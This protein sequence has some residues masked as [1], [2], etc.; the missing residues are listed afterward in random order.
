MR[1][2]FGPLAPL[3]AFDSDEEVVEQ[4]ND[5]EFGL[6]AYIYTNNLSRVWKVSEALEYGMV[7]VNTPV[8]ATPEAL[9][10]RGLNPPGWA[11]RALDTG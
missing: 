2:L 4:A 9:V 6:A 7:G 11:A 3:V 8:L 1:R 5:T 10:W